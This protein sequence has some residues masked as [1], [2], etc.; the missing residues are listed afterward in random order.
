MASLPQPSGGP[1]S[2]M[3]QFSE[4][5]LDENVF[6]VTFKDNSRVPIEKATDL[7]LQR[8]AE[9]TLEKGYK[10]FVI[11]D[12]ESYTAESKFTAGDQDSP[13]A[14]PDSTNIIV[15]FKEKPDSDFAYHANSIRNKNRR[16]GRKY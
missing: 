12:P 2:N 9:L 15:C 7:T 6:K 1:V 5:Q 13:A 4:T 3:G 8:C 14:E 11:I 10:Y 16:L